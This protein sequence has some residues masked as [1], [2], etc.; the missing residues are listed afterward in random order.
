MARRKKITIKPKEKPW[1]TSLF[2]PFSVSGLKPNTTY[3]SKLHVVDELGD[4]TEWNKDI[5]F[6]TFPPTPIIDSFTVGLGRPSDKN[7]VIKF[8]LTLYA[9]IK[10]IQII[11]DDGQVLYEKNNSGQQKDFTV[12]IGNLTPERQYT[13]FLI[14]EDIHGQTIKSKYAVIT[15]MPEK[16]VITDLVVSNRGQDF[17]E[18]LVKYDSKISI[19]NY[20]YEVNNTTVNTSVNPYKIG[21]LTIGTEYAVEVTISDANGNISEPFTKSFYTSTDG[22]IITDIVFS[23][24][25]DTTAVATVNTT[26]TLPVKDYTF[27]FNNKSQTQTTNTFELTDLTPYTEYYVTVVARDELD[28]PS[29][30]ITRSFKTLDDG[31]VVS[32]CNFS[33]ITATTIDVD[34]EFSSKTPIKQ[35]EVY[36]KF[37]QDNIFNFKEYNKFISWELRKGTELTL[38]TNGIPSAGG[39]IKFINKD[40]TEQWFA[41]DAGLTRVVRNLQAEV[42]GYY[43]LLKNTTGIDYNLNYGKQYNFL[44]FTGYE[45]DFIKLLDNLYYSNDFTITG[46]RPNSQLYKAKFLITNI[47]DKTIE[48]QTNVQLELN[49]SNFYIENIDVS[50]I[51]DD[52]ATISATINSDYDI[53]KYELY[54]NDELKLTQTG[55]PFSISGLT[56]NTKYKAEIIGYN[57]YNWKIQR[58]TLFT[59]EQ[60]KI[61]VSFETGDG[62]DIQG[63][64]VDKGSK[65]NLDEYVTEQEGYNFLGWYIGDTKYQGEYTVNSDVVFTAKWEIKQLTITYKSFDVVVKTEKVNYGDNGTPPVLEEVDGYD[66]VEWSPEPLNVTQ[67]MTVVAVFTRWTTEVTYNTGVSQS[68]YI[69]Q[70]E[71]QNVEFGTKFTTATMQIPNN[72]RTLLGWIYTNDNFEET[73]YDPNTEYTMNVLYNMPMMAKYNKYRTFFD[74]LSSTNPTIPSQLVEV[75]TEIN[76]PEMTNYNTGIDGRRYDATLLGISAQLTFENVIPTTQKTVT[77]AESDTTYYAYWEYPIV[78]YNVDNV[79]NRPKTLTARSDSIT[80]EPEQSTEN[81]TFLGWTVYIDGL[82][83]NN[84]MYDS[85]IININN[86]GDARYYEFEANWKYKADTTIMNGQDFNNKIKDSFG[87]DN[88]EDVVFTNSISS[89]ANTIDVSSNRTNQVVAWIETVSENNTLFIASNIEEKTM[90]MPQDMSYMFSNMKSA[91]RVLFKYVDFSNVTSLNSTFKNFGMNVEGIG[92]QVGIYGTNNMFTNCTDTQDMF[93]NFGYKAD[94]VIL[95]E[96]NNWE[97]SKVTRANSMF[98]GLGYDAKNVLLGTGKNWNLRALDEL[99]FAFSDFARNAQLTNS[100]ELKIVKTTTSSKTDVFKNAVLTSSTPFLVYDNGNDAT[101]DLAEQI[102]ATKSENSKVFHVRTINYDPNGGTM[103]STYVKEYTGYA[104]VELPIPTKENHEFVAWVRA[105]N[106]KYPTTLPSGLQGKINLVAEYKEHVINTKMITGKEFQTKLKEKVDINN[107]LSVAFKNTIDSNVE[108]NPNFIDL[109]IGQDKQVVAYT[110]EISTGKYKLYIAANLTNNKIIANEDCSEMFYMMKNLQ[111]I[112][113][114]KIFDM[115]NTTTVTKMFAGMYQGNQKEKAVIFGLVPEY[116]RKVVNADEMFAGFG[117]NSLGANIEDMKYWQFDML[118]SANNMFDSVFYQGTNFDIQITQNWSLRSLVSANEMFAN[119]GDGIHRFNHNIEIQFVSEN[120]SVT[121]MFFGAFEDI[122]D[123]S[124]YHFLIYDDDLLPQTFDIAEKVANPAHAVYHVRNIE[125][126]ANGGQMP[127]SYNGQY[128]GYE[129]VVLPTPRKT[130]SVFKG[131]ERTVSGV[132]ETYTEKLPKNLTG[133]IEL[134]AKWEEVDLSF[135]K[136]S[137]SVL[138][139]VYNS[140]VDGSPM[141]A[142]QLSI[143]VSGKNIHNLSYEWTCKKHT[144]DSSGEHIGEELFNLGNAEV[145]PSAT[146]LT[147]SWENGAEYKGRVKVKNTYNEAYYEESFD[148]MISCLNM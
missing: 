23:E 134:V 36:I 40:D 44:P 138:Q 103:P 120:I 61:S 66:F 1:F 24:I 42:K 26:S 84:G 139:S 146:I 117:I 116:F 57:K 64:E 53:V 43:N 140:P 48:Y 86:V 4:R 102:V 71:S 5:V 126:N 29:A 3:T 99:S 121:D 122:A 119:A 130:G 133:R 65:I 62:S 60:E 19:T 10:N 95:S 83:D 128:A 9:D 74:V 39:N 63:L 38:L 2:N 93:Y 77:Q 75:G 129:E 52:S 124:Q 137:S 20:K 123:T 132:K 54:I 118:E 111:R 37:N 108:N 49:K 45:S 68:D 85:Y 73:V 90:I 12:N 35:I 107:I 27:Y 8:S 55:L 41:I 11:T 7:I 89:N 105:S 101:F 28:I 125:Y 76:I 80:I 31:V 115:S 56:P 25:T 58:A 21:G 50:N 88:I 46:L 114:N 142:D 47:A 109:S 6:K 135:T 32:S 141:T 96:A 70:P 82:K 100:P 30:E 143:S 144:Y 127:T 22:P 34:F 17:L 110:E 79:E 104:S 136:D 78:Y 16:P 92:S 106:E 33:N 98:N 67:D 51:E 113:F 14:V 13:L 69:A 15:M 87:L 91:F 94:R 18:V 147:L 72:E 145:V 131:W 112:E 97:M 81:K 59:T 148:F